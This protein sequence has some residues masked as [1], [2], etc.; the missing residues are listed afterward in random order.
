MK[1]E[2]YCR[3]CGYNNYPDEFWKATIPLYTICPCCGCESGNE[4]YTVE[5]TKRY[6]EKW[7]REG[8]NWFSSKER[9]DKWDREEQ[10]KNIPPRSA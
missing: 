4:D 9:P 10:F 5:S 7:I 2:Y 6:R 1:Q 8:N 3:V